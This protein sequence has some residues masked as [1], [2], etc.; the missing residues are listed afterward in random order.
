MDLRILPIAL[1]LGLFSLSSAFAQSTCPSG[2]KCRAGTHCQNNAPE[3]KP[4][5][6]ICQPDAVVTPSPLTDLS[7]A[8]TQIGNVAYSF[9]VDRRTAHVMME[10]FKVGGGG[11][12][13]T[14]LGAP[15]SSQGD[16]ATT[17]PSAT[18]VPGSGFIVL[19]VANKDHH[20][21][22][23]QGHDQSWTGWKC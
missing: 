5:R 10:F 12:N 6:W 8:W 15:T 23:N 17:G 13:W 19:T 11:G 9:A 14:D 4:E 16:G 21:C 2:L 7:Q 20:I 1:G 3:G 18:S 22:L